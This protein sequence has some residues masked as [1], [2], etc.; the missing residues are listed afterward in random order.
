MLPQA[1]LAA[2]KME[3]KLGCLKVAHYVD[4][5]MMLQ[6]L[7]RLKHVMSFD[8]PRAMSDIQVTSISNASLTNREDSYGQT[9]LI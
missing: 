8:M 6:E 5:I 3:Q 9:G 7:R 1:C 4:A 2:S